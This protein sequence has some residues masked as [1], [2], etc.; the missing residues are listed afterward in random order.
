MEKYAATIGAQYR[1]DFDPNIAGKACDVPMYFEWLNP[2]LDDTFLAYERVLVVD[3]DVFAVEGLQEDIFAESVS[4]IGICTEPFQ[5]EYRA[6]APGP[7]CRVNDERWA[8]EVR[9]NWGV[10]MPREEETG[11]LKVY[12][13]GVV[14]FTRAGLLKAREKFIPFQIYVDRMRKAKLPRFY[15][16]DQNYFHAM[17]FVAGIPYTE[18]HN[19]WN[20]YIQYTGPRDVSPRPVHDERTKQTKFVHIQLSGADDFD[21]EKL[22]RITNC[23]FSQW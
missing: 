23:T 10:R 7:I 13:A 19:G 1:C 4:E 5:P 20:S 15:T 9:A 17:L 3:M 8:E 14:L 21:S 22:W 2:L 6:T 16:V 12:N 18:L 11:R